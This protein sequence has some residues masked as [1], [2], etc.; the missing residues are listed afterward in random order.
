MRQSTPKRSLTVLY[1][2]YFICKLTTLVGTVQAAMI[3]F[4]KSKAKTRQKGS[5]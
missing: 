2:S 4:L 1:R 5:E 3:R